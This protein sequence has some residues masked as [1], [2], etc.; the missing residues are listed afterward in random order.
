MERITDKH[1][2][3]VVS[4]LNRETGNPATYRAPDCGPIN[5]GHY[6]IDRAYGGNQL[7]QI[8]NTGGGV[9]NVL[10]CGFVTKRALYDLIYAYIS[11]IDAGKVAK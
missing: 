4:R 1:L 10:N 9:R 3:A 2:E 8:T 5:V 6:Y 11:G 7:V